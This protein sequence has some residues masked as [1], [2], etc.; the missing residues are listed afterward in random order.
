VQGPG[1]SGARVVVNG[2]CAMTLLLHAI[3]GSVLVSKLPGSHVVRRGESLSHVTLVAASGCSVRV[4]SAHCSRVCAR[5]RFVVLVRYLHT[6]LFA[7]APV[8]AGR[9]ATCYPQAATLAGVVGVLELIVCVIIPPLLLWRAV[10]SEKEICR[11]NAAAS[12]SRA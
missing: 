9:E 10:A 4:R 1:E 7:A 5:A 8:R 6:N 3:T 11:Q 2:M 12:A